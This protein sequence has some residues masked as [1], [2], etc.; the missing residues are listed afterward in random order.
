[1]GEKVTIGLAGIIIIVMMPC[2]LTLFINGRQ[3]NVPIEKINS[4]RDVLI[5]SQGE[6]ILMDVEQ[7]IVG[8]LPGL[9]EYGA[10]KELVE[11]QAVAVRTKIYYAM[12]ENTVINA[13]NLEFEYFDDKKYINK[14]GMNNYEAVRS[15]FEEAVISTSGQ[16]IDSN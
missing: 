15:I 1:M 6:N 16:I 10:Q 5:L 13:E 12:G 2:L 11:A 3:A 14:Y 9:I 4:G 7:Y 8:V